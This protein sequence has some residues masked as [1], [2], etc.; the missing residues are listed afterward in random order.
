MKTKTSLWILSCVGLASLAL[1]ASPSHPS[2]DELQ[3]WIAGRAVAVRTIDPADEDF[4]DLD[5]LIDAIGSARVVQLGEPS[6]GAGGSFAAKVRL[7]KF[8][9]QRMGFD[10]LAW[11]SGLYDVN[12]TQRGIRAGDDPVIA[13]QAGILLVWS[14][15]EEVRPLFEYARASQSTGRPLD[16]AGFDSTMNAGNARDRF[17]ADLR[18]FFK[19]L[20]DKALRQHADELAEQA[21]AAHQRLSARHEMARRIELESVRAAVSGKA[22]AQSPPEAM[23][24]WA[25]SDEAKLLGRKEDIETLD[26]AADGLLAM[27]RSQRPAFLRVHA[28]RQITFMERVLENL[29]ANDRKLYDSER[30]DRPAA[31]AAG[32]PHYNEKWNR[33]DALNTRNLHWLLE[34]GYPGRKI[35]VWAHNVHLMNAYYGAQVSS[36]HIEPQAGG[37]E[38]SGVALARWLGNDV[39]TIAMTSYEGE[40]GWNSA[41]SIAPA[42]DGSLEWRLHQL[43]KPYVFLDLRACDGDSGHPMRKPQSMRIDKYRDDTLT[44]VTRAFDAI[45]YLDPMTPA[46]LIRSLS[47]Q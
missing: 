1:A 26:R 41:K 22:L 13:A 16:M 12:L 33:R 38:P 21:I 44:D 3:K 18:S 7:I 14:A 32:S 45:F 40:D 39:Y 8:L 17:A 28:T 46:T 23:A 42:P 34:E 24:A 35:I 37:L 6:H 15:T 30:P 9:H 29:R 4:H 43:G 11:E 25:K 27:I 31:R 19:A 2:E 47:K 5:P 36:I 10:V 20:H